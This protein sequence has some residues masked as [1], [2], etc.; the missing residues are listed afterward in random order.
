M[1]KTGIKEALELNVEHS[2]FIIIDQNTDLRD[3]EN[4][5]LRLEEKLLVP[6]GL[7]KKDK[8]METFDPTPS[9]FLPL[10]MMS[11]NQLAISQYV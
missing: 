4:F 6:I 5:R 2:H 9:K 10:N 7:G 1:K 3:L 11:G 8:K